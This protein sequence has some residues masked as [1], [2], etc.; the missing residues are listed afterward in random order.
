MNSL[1]LR[2]LIKIQDLKDR[3]EGQD[4]VE[5]AMAVALIAFG[6][7]AGMKALAKGLDTAFNQISSTLSTTV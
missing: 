4:L 7:V 3:T 2:L 5:Y 1:L 6:A